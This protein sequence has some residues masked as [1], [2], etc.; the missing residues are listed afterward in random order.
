MEGAVPLA[1]GALVLVA[2][3]SAGEPTACAAVLES[4]VTRDGVSV[5]CCTGDMIELE[6]DASSCGAASLLLIAERTSNAAT[7]VSVWMVPA[8]A[9]V[10]PVV[11]SVHRCV[12]ISFIVMR[13]FGRS[14]NRF[15]H[16]A[17]R[18]PEQFRGFSHDT[19]EKGRP[20]KNSFDIVFSSWRLN[21]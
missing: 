9:S 5:A 12:C 20:A 6:T 1:P 2:V 3:A 11:S 17:M 7:G 13:S 15:I 21:G 10:T 14:R 4:A 16:S 8:S 18:A 19:L